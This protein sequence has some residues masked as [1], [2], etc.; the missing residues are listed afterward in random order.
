MQPAR[1]PG[2]AKAAILERLWTDY[3]RDPSKWCDLRRNKRNPKAPDFRHR[4]T[5][6]L[7]WTDNIRNPS[8]VGSMLQKLDTQTSVRIP[9]THGNTSPNFEEALSFVESATSDQILVHKIVPLLLKCTK[10]KNLALATR[11]HSLLQ[12]NELDTHTSLG[13]YVVPMLTE[14]GS[15]Q[16]AQSVFDRFV[17]V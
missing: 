3:F 12:K 13:N 7:L 14:V 16:E 9:E 10:E 5:H 6:D 11:V 17:P 1:P 2:I 8:W 4:A 15:L